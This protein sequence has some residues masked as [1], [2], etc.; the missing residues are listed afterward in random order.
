VLGV[1]G[2]VG[3]EAVLVGG[4]ILN[5]NFNNLIVPSEADSQ[6]FSNTVAWVNLG[7]GGDTQ[8]TR[9]APAATLYDDGSRNAVFSAGTTK[10]FALDT[11][12][13]IGKGQSFSIS[14][15]WR[16]AS[17]WA[18][19]TDQVHVA[20]FVT[21]D[22]TITGVRTNL[23][24]DFSGT[25]TA[26]NTYEEVVRE[27]LYTAVP[28]DYGK[29][30][31]VAI[32]TEQASGFSRLDNFVLTVKGLAFA[33][34]PSPPDGTMLE[35]TSTLLQWNPGDFAVSHDVYFSD[36]FADVNDGL[37]APVATTETSLSMTDLVPGTTYYWRVDAVNG[38]NPDSPW[39]G[40]VWS[41][42]LP[43]LSAYDPSPAAGTQYV[44]SDSALGWKPGLGSLL[45]Y[46]YFGTDPNALGDGDAQVETTFVP[47]VPLEAGTTYYWR[48]DEFDASTAVTT[49]G[50]LW[51]F[52][53]VPQIDI[54][55]E[56][57]LGHWTLDDINA[58]SA[59]D[60]SGHAL[61]G[62]ISGAPEWIDGI[63]GAAVSL[64]GANDYFTTPAP[65]DV[66][67]N[68][69]TFTAWIKPTKVHGWA[70]IIFTRDTA[71][72]VGGLNLKAD[73]QLSYHWAANADTYGFDS[74]LVPLMNEWSFVALVIEPERATFYLNGTDITAENAIAHPAMPFTAGIA[75]GHD[76]TGTRRFGGA[77]DDLRLYT[78][79]LTAVEIEQVMAAG[80]KP[81]PTPED[82]AVIE[83]FDGYN[84]YE[85][86]TGQDVWDVW[87]DG[88]GGNGTGS[89]LGVQ[90]PIME[91]AIV[92]GNRGQSL[93]VAYNNSGSFIDID[94]KLVNATISEISRTFSP[95][96]D[97]T[98]GG[99]TRLVLYM[100][101]A[102][103]NTVNT[104]E[105]T[106]NAYLLL[107]DGVNTDEV[108]L[109]A[110]EDLT[111]TT[112]KEVSIDL[113]TLTVNPAAV[114]Q[115]TLGVGS[116][117]APQVGGTGTIYIDQITRK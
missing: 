102:S 26:N 100:R 77:M 68:T 33:N 101:G 23:V 92:V 4:D 116:R 79:S 104:L 7:T 87:S 94:G 95:T 17:G 18:D 70:G 52:T 83:S 46:V 85:A 24:E 21:D 48:V 115:I 62:A 109:L 112:W 39:K 10:V 63:A 93:P 111:T 2:T 45:H 3:A 76:P 53:V 65:V 91:R 27:D 55:D 30:L 113:N 12:H 6:L 81:A 19:A 28:A 49:T 9:T 86:Q 58:G 15:V 97:L 114:T 5:G 14:Y 105:P 98:A 47:T 13:A 61:H 67:S 42:T 44:L 34:N 57:L 40:T 41:F 96:L 73:N 110:S 108:Q 20:L 64:D 103:A 75:L 32:D 25:S 82:P 29:I 88:Y 11:G 51:S 50:D 106:D 1:A 78:R 117:T 89:W 35:A 56:S 37:V 31:F 90:Y 99:A 80:T 69:V 107:T 16:D 43:P 84:A 72:S 74:T 36:N 54:Q 8:A 59:V 38:A 60:W 22:N 71:P 66:N